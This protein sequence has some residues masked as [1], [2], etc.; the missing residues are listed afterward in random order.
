MH[1]AK[2][3]QPGI[4]REV[5]CLLCPRRCHIK[6]GAMGV[7]GVRQNV[8]GR[9]Y[10]LVFGNPVAVHVDPVEKK[11]LYH[12][13]PGSRVFSI[14]TVGCN[15]K[16]SF[17]Q[18]WD[19]STIGAQPTER[20]SF[21]PEDIVRQ[22]LAQRCQSIAFTY[23]E[24]TIFGEYVLEIAQL[25]QAAGLKTIMVTNG[26]IS[27]EAIADIYPLIDGANIDLKAFTDEFYQKLCSAYLTPVLES[28]KAIYHEGT[29][30]E[31]TTLLIPGL[32]D[33]AAEI[34]NLTHWIHE[35]LGDDV[36]LHFSA[37]HPDYNLLD[38]RATPKSTLDQARR[39]AQEVG[40]HYVYEGNVAT[41]T[42]GN[43][44]CPQCGRLLIERRFFTAIKRSLR[45]KHCECGFEIPLVL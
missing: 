28:I 16:C 19:I 15:F 25:A 35:N 8:G 24:P 21:S 29:F 27:Q 11:P 40:L 14:G 32:N 39:I 31:L 12:F 13:Q 42:E 7:C 26:Y 33:S 36:P 44:Y 43:T 10:S 1:E 45:E 37:F 34:R 2:W 20:I 30:I 5:N 4:G 17:C 6:D 3:W 22:A 9:L 18:N 38:R 41:A 23:N